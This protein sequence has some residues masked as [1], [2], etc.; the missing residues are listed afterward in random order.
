MVKIWVVKANY[1]NFEFSYMQKKKK[2]NTT[3]R[4]PTLHK[5]NSTSPIET[6]A[7]KTNGLKPIYVYIYMQNYTFIIKNLMICNDILLVRT[8]F[9][10]KIHQTWVHICY[11]FDK[12]Q[13]QEKKE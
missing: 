10:P 13:H 12:R 2:G 8:I 3:G 6:L 11:E 9:L 7:S 1:F 5:T 4:G